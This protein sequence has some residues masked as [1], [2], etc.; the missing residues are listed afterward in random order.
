MGQNLDTMRQQQQQHHHHQRQPSKAELLYEVVVTTGNVDAI[1]ALFQEGASLEWI[2]RDGKN[3]L[4]TACMNPNLID[5]AKTL[6]ELGANINSYRPGRH[7]GT[8]LHHAVKKGLEQTVALLLSHGANPLVRNDDCQTPLDVARLTGHINVVRTLENHICYFSGWVREIIPGFLGAIA[9]NLLSKKLWVVVIP[10][11]PNNRIK[12]LKLELAVYYTLKDAQPC[13]VISLW[14]A[15]IEK[16][17]LHQSDPT[18]G[19]F[20]DSIKSQLKLASAIKGDKQQIQSLYDACQGIS[21]VTP[22]SVN[23]G[24]E[25]SVEAGELAMLSDDFI[26][27][28]AGD[29]Q[30]APNSHQIPEVSNT[31]G[32]GMSVSDDSYNGWGSAVGTTHAQANSRGW[33]DEQAK[34]DYNGWNVDDSRPLGNPTKHAQTHGTTV[35]S[36]NHNVSASISSA[37][38]A[39]PIPEEHLVEGPIHYPSIDI[40]TDV[41]TQPIHSE[42]STLYETKAGNDSSSCVICWDSPIEGACIPCGHMAGCMS[43]LT[44][45]KAKKGVCPVCRSTINQ[46]VRLYPV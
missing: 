21:Q 46:V 30:L 27:S 7:A 11:G 24:S 13:T 34:D 8:P 33:M 18:L 45:I 39:P 2:D 32:W 43:C 15:R 23:H 40:G 1:K 35:V 36:A 14:K 31:N 6:I 3:P 28:A 37:P 29:T 25:N 10:H 38:S 42:A 17:N 26:Q 41:S 19:I 20:D 12:P 4:I 9:S 5:T 16:P 44:E 22:P